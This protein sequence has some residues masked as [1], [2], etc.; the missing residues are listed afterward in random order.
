[1]AE[2]VQALTDVEAGRAQRIIA[3]GECKVRREVLK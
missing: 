1:M 3:L 2:L